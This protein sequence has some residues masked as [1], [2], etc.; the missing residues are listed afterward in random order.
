M[1]ALEVGAGPFW[2][3]L[4]ILAVGRALPVYPAKQTFSV[5]VGMSQTCQNPNQL[6]R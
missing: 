3:N 4:V 5:S 6:Q 1:N 2:V